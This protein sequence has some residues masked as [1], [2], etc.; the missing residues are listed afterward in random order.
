MW[1]T[2]MFYEGKAMAELGE[3]KNL[4]AFVM[5]RNQMTRHIL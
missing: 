4:S 2:P 3:V 1:F 5:K